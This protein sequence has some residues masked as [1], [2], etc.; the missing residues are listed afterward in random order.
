M[1]PTPEAHFTTLNTTP[2][3][4]DDLAL[5]LRHAP[6]IRFD[7]REPFLP[8]VVGYTIFRENAPSPSFPRQIELPS[9]AVLAIEYAV[10]W[11]WEIQHLYEL[12]HLW[13]YLDA[14]EKVILAEASWHGGYH[15][16]VDENGVVP[17]EN[18]KVTVYSEP[19]KH[20]FAPTPS[21]LIDRAPVT[22]ASCGIHSGKMGV[23]VTPLFKGN[24][25]DRIPLNDRL[26]HTYLERLAFEPTFAF[27][28]VFDLAD[29]VFVAW[30][31]LFQWIPARVK[32]WCGY[33]SET[34]PPHERRFLRIAH[35]GASAYAQEG[36]RASVRK[37]LELG[38]DMVEVDVRITADDVPVIAHDSDLHR[39]FG[40]NALVSDVTYQEILDL[41]P[42]ELEPVLTFEEMAQQC[43]ALGLGLYLDIKEVSPTAM[44]SIVESLNG[45]GL[46]KYS[47]FG[48]FRPD[49]VAEIKHNIPDAVTSILFASPNV[50]PVALAQSIR[51]DYVHP[52]FERFDTPH[53]LISGRWM[54]RVR[55]AGLGVVCWHEERP[56]IIAELQALGVDGVCSDMPELLVINAG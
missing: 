49:F 37:A 51:S 29:A 50:D 2:L 44:A 25:H 5:A 34:I 36:S 13:I 45:Y 17:M 43:A 41:T 56:H 53:E 38:A 12:E 48:S 55:E 54:E 23:H 10:W 19:G 20:A 11:D 35:R 9:D 24:I 14:Q 6:H 26:V 7:A 3:S 31:H 16:M 40:I 4:E 46:L 1:Y 42:I 22:V 39:V 30:D 15:Q 52:C 21:H 8:S 18:G 33:L 47:I 28:Q 32:W 27:S